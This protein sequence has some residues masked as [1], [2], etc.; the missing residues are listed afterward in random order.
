MKTN[1]IALLLVFTVLPVLLTAQRKPVPEFNTRH[2]NIYVELLGSH[3]YHGVNFDMRLQKGRLDGPGIRVGIGGYGTT[4][5]SDDDF[6]RL[7]VITVPIEFNHLVGKGRSS[8]VSGVGLLP[9]YATASAK[10]SFTAH[11]YVQ[12]DGLA[13]MGGFLNL[14]Y[15]YQ[16][17]KN[18]LMFQINWNPMIIRGYGFEPAWF[19]VGIG[20]G[21]K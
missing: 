21:F 2:K 4:A 17:K 15:R 5:R 19:G 3:L 8:F 18:G 7:G 11:E 14:G 12:G 9:I 13:L 6:I 10:G 20:M 1:L 16:P